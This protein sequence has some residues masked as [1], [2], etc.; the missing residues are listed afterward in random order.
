MRVY[1]ISGMGADRR[2][3]KNICLPAGF[4]PVFVDWITP[5]P[6]ESLAD[7]A[8]RLSE[9]IDRSEPFI[10]LGTSL[11]GIMAMEIAKR[12]PPVSTILI[13]SVPISAH[14]P[15]YYAFARS[16]GLVSLLPPSFF[17]ATATI[18]RRFTRESA[19]D[20]ELIRQIIR[21][22]DGPFIKWAMNAVLEWDNGEIPQPLWHIHGTRDEVFPVWLTRPT[23]RIRHAGHM[24]V[25]SHAQE[26]NA[27]LRKILLHS[28]V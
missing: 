24:L 25:M 7:Y 12:W 18:K 8:V 20:K 15:R 28:P 1:F 14:L 10:L 27:I 6:K 16:V 23:H 26:V 21:E 11:G 19:E 5:V 2:I 9:Q 17:K 22:S 4:E 3:Y 13:S